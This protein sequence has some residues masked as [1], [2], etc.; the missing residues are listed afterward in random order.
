[1]TSRPLN[2]SRDD[3]ENDPNIVINALK[4]VSIYGEIDAV[5]AAAAKVPAGEIKL[6]NGWPGPR[7]WGWRHVTRAPDRLPAIVRAGHATELS[8]AYDVGQ[9][10]DTLHAGPAGPGIR[11]SVGMKRGEFYPALALSWNNRFWSITTMLP[12]RTVN[13]PILYKK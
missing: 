3:P 12:F 5:A 11:V 8:F 10:W 13:Y 9:N 6:L 1:M 2:D 4:G 7:G